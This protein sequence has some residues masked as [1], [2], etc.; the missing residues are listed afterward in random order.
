MESEDW[1]GWEW[2]GEL[3]GW[4]LWKELTCKEKRKMSERKRGVV[5]AGREVES[6]PVVAD[7]RRLHA[8]RGALECSLKREPVVAPS[9]PS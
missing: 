3:N 1:K 4:M 5:L 9:P 2:L 6:E 7:R 8:P